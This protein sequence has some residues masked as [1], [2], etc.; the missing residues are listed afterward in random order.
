MHAVP[1]MHTC[2]YTVRRLQ[3]LPPGAGAAVARSCTRCA[4]HTLCW[5]LQPRRST[6]R[7]EPARPAIMRPSNYQTRLSRNA[8]PQADRVK[9]LHVRN[10]WCTYA[11]MCHETALSHGVRSASTP[12]RAAPDMVVAVA[13]MTRKDVRIGISASA[14][15]CRG[16]RRPSHGLHG[17]PRAPARYTQVR[18]IANIRNPRA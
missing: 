1:H 18:W 3:Q 5:A 16:L 14:L 9:G 15:V 12:T 6:R 7:A 11:P 2:T 13:N 8:Y 10:A 4:G 17:R